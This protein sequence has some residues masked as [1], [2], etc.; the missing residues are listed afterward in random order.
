[1]SISLFLRR[2]RR[3]EW[4]GPIRT[5]RLCLS[6]FATFFVCVTH[7]AAQSPTLTVYR[8]AALIDG[9][10]AALKRDVAIVVDGERIR[11]TVPD[12]QAAPYLRG[13]TV[14]DVHGLYALPVLLDAHVHG[15]PPPNRRYAEALLRR[16]VYSGVTAVRDMAGDARQ[17]A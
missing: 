3:V 11:A 1:M 2:M 8:G 17:L 16:D 13:A 15:G 10:G 12:A 5:A 7:A 14:V 9:T 6:A 4:A